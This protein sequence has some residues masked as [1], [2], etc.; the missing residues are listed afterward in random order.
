MIDVM[1]EKD[2]VSFATSCRL[3]ERGRTTRRRGAALRQAAIERFAE[4]GF[5][6]PHDEE[7]RFTSA[8]RRSPRSPFDRLAATARR[9]ARS[10]CRAC[11]AT[12]GP[13][14]RLVFVNGRFA[15]SCL[16]LG[17]LPAGVQVGSLAEALDANAAS[18]WSRT[19]PATPLRRHAFH[20]PQHRLPPRWRLRRICRAASSL[21]KPIHL[22]YVS[23]AGGEA[24]RRPSAHAHRLRQATARR[25][26]SK[27]IVGVRAT[28]SISP[29]PSPRLSLGANAHVDHYK[30]QRES[31]QA[32]HIATLQV[33][34]DR[35]SNFAS[36]SISLGGGLVRNEVNAVLDGE[37]CECTLNG[38]YLAAG[39]SIV[40]NHTV[41]DHAKPHCASHE[42]YKGILDGKATASSTARSSSARTP[43]RPTPSR[44]TR[45]CCCPTTPIIDTKPQ[46]EIFADDVKCTHGATVGQLDAEAIFYLRSR[47]IGLDEAAQPA[48]LRLRQR[49]RRPDQGRAAA[50]R[51]WKNCCW[52]RQHLPADAGG[53][54]MSI[55]STATLSPTSPEQP[56]A[57][58]STSSGSASDFPILQQKVHGKPLVYLDNAA[59]TQK[60]RA[61]LD[62]L[63]HY[64]EHDNAN[65]HRGVHL[66]SERA[67]DAYEEARV[68]VQQF[69]NAPCL[70]EIIFTRG[71]TEAINLVAHSFGRQERAGRR[72]GRSSPGWSTTPTSSP[73]RCSARRSGATLRVVPI[74]DAGELRLDE[75]EKLLDAA[76]QARRRRAR[77]QRAGHDQPGQGDHRAGPRR[78]VPVLIDGAQAVPHMR[79]DV[80]ELDCDFYAFSGHKLYGPTGIGVL[81]GKAELLERCRPT[82]AAAT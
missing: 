7:W 50:P 14:M 67:T 64:Y 31:E 21:S 54:V 81:Y 2:A 41:I 76:D 65:V 47:G 73:G 51:S 82:R 15:P 40:D 74:T 37:G 78:G 69:L 75:F 28:T 19:W 27:P 60:P 53:G 6:T 30:V 39:R 66:L 36:H 25:P 58:A 61:V 63:N 10:A 29:T 45:R 71:T 43:R 8:R 34:Q 1:D 68:K 33:Q 57:A 12:T 72:R 79:V 5:P 44:P 35:G 49:H 55:H 16:A 56:T 24:D 42:L 59:T 18:W 26:S 80:Q 32:F 77:L 22:V 62:A 48:D 70:R 4:L 46:L 23:P 38:L 9:A 3:R 11:V 13:R 52:P 17:E 20:R